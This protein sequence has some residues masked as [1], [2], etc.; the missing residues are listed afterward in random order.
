MR[1]KRVPNTNVFEPDLEAL[2]T[3]SAKIRA[4]AHLIE[5]LVPQS[6]ETLGR[7]ARISS[8]SLTVSVNGFLMRT[9]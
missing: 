9:Q 3:E 2:R 4:I 1:S 8:R 6:V 5:G 7:V